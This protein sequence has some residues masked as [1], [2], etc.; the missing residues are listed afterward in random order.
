[1]KFDIKN[2][3]S[4]LGK[5]LKKAAYEDVTKQLEIVKKDG[6]NVVQI[7]FE[8]NWFAGNFDYTLDTTEKKI[9]EAAKKGSGKLY[10]DLMQ[11]V[12]AYVF[13]DDGSINYKTEYED[14]KNKG[15]WIIGKGT[16]KAKEE[17]IYFANPYLIPDG[18]NI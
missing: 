14:K 2:L 18:F 3:P 8:W 7:T 12:M 13:N 16:I 9:L 4:D 6:K 1:M 11:C 15:K 17:S 10:E 5:R